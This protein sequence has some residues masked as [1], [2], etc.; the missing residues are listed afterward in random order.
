MH[1]RFSPDSRTSLEAL[2]ER[3]RELRLDRIALTDHNTVAGALELRRLAPDTTIVGE[4]VSTTEGDIIGLFISGPIPRGGTP[5]EVCDAI[6]EMGGLTYACHPF[7]RRRAHFRPER[8]A[9]LAGHLDIIETHNPWCDE[10]ANQAAAEMCRETGRVAASGSDAHAP[11]ELGQ[12]WM[13]IDPYSDA[14]D[15]LRKLA[16]ARHVIMRTLRSARRA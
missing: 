9:E 4:E 5:E 13:E 14:Q 10:T 1:S 3:T 7:D 8:L 2:I 12:C 6:H 11:H 16:D 15:F